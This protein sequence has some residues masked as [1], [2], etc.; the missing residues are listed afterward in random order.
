MS[1]AEDAEEQQ[2][3]EEA[4]LVT[5]CR[6]RTTNQAGLGEQAYQA[7][8]GRAAPRALTE[9]EGQPDLGGPGSQLRQARHPRLNRPEH[10]RRTRIAFVNGK[11]IYLLQDCHEKPRGRLGRWGAIPPRVN[12]AA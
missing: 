6:P 12:R 4:G 9:G 11:K 7:R 1:A 3:L 5:F 10:V 2:E 8:R